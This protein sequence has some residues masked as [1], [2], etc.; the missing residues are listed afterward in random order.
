VLLPFLPTLVAAPLAAPP[1]RLELSLVVVG[2]WPP[3]AG[4]A[5]S[6]IPDL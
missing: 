1:R 5:I 2:A 6:G 4:S 3:C